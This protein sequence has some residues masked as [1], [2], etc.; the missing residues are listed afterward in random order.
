MKAF[1]LKNTNESI[2]WL[3]T[4]ALVNYAVDGNDFIVVSD[5]EYDILNEVPELYQKVYFSNTANIFKL[6]SSCDLVILDFDLDMFANKCNSYQD[7]INLKINSQLAPLNLQLQSNKK[8]DQVIS[9]CDNHQFTDVFLSVKDQTYFNI[10]KEHLDKLVNVI[11]YDDNSIADLYYLINKCSFVVSDNRIEYLISNELAKP[12]FTI[13]DNLK[14]TVEKTDNTFVFDPF[15]NE[16]HCLP[17]KIFN[18]DRERT[19]KVNS[20][21]INQNSVKDLLISELNDALDKYKISYVTY[22]PS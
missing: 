9:N 2:A 3:C 18:K 6:V 12:K 21:I 5:K 10:C 14:V 17:P 11:T 8:L 4:K 20:Q 16:T 13:V 1:I 19:I 7:Y 22:L 15:K